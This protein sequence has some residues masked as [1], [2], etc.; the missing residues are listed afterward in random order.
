MTGRGVRYRRELI[1][2]SRLD[3]GRACTGVAWKDSP[4]IHRVRVV[5]GVTGLEP[6]GL[7]SPARQTAAQGETIRSTL[8]IEIS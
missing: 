4:V 6:Q 7:L 8:V 3:V 2:E 1:G 5:V